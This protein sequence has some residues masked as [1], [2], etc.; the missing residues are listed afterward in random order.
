MDQAPR[1]KKAKKGNAIRITCAARSWTSGEKPGAI[2]EIIVDEKVMPTRQSAPEITRR[3]E[4]SARVRW[5]EVSL[6]QEACTRDKTGMKAA[7]R[8]PSPRRVLK[9]LGIR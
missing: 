2:A 7:E 5:T 3:I 1:V 4:K 8:L 6:P 9:K